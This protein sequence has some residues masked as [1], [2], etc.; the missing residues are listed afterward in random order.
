[1]IAASVLYLFLLTLFFFLKDQVVFNTICY[2]NSP[3]VRFCCDDPETCTDKFIRSNFDVTL[4]PKLYSGGR[5]IEDRDLKLLYGAPHCSLEPVPSEKVWYFSE[6]SQNYIF[7]LT[8]AFTIVFSTAP[9]S[10]NKVKSVSSRISS[11]STSTACKI[12]KRRTVMSPNGVSS[13]AKTTHRCNATCITCVSRPAHLRDRR[14]IRFFFSDIIVGLFRRFNFGAIRGLQ[15]A[16]NNSG[17]M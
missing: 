2:H 11:T 12:G 6:V 16:E 3:C 14:L 9:S 4:L 13:S 5:E 10:W 7:G 15:R 1:M 17:Q 8:V